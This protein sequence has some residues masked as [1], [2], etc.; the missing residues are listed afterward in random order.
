MFRPKK[1][2]LVVTGALMM[3]A[4]IALSGCGSDGGESPSAAIDPNASPESVTGALTVMRNPGEMTDEK[5]DDFKAQYPN[6]DLTV[7]DYDAVKLASLQAAG[8]AP[9]V[10]R[11][12]GPAVAP[13]VSQGLLLDLTAPFESAGVT[14]DTTYESANIYVFDGKRYGLPKDWS[15]DLTIF[16]NKS[17]F[18]QAGV[19]VPDPSEPI[20]W[21]EVRKLAADVKA[22]LPASSTIIPF[23]GAWDTFSPARFISAR[24]AESGQTLYSED[25]K[26]LN[27]VD[28]PD[29]VGFLQYMADMAKDG[30]TFSPLNPSA[31]YAGDDFTKGNVAMAM[32]GYWFNSQVN[33]GETAVGVNYSMIP[34]P[35]WSDQGSRVDPT[36]TGTGYVVSAGTKNPQ[37]AWEL[38][39]WYLTGDE[40]GKRA[41][42]AAGLPVLRSN[43]DL[44]PQDSD[45]NKQAFGVVTAEA[46][47]SPALQFNKYYDDSVFTTSYNKSLQEYLAGSISIEQVAQNIQDEVSA[48]IQDGVLAVGD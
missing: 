21:D 22:G 17:I 26:T 46:E 11:V 19:S 16:I 6:I 27:L 43:V 1:S 42:A 20:S 48:A 8:S 32:Y 34:A 40:A 38:M 7:I 35:Y 37:A 12:E 25:Q 33:S 29:A 10:F 45:V 44:L 24:L 47:D 14:D 23:G 2:R 39:K 36:V 13:L 9:D 41:E 5:L 3:A 31:S 30:L 18:Q 28:N 15:P 4:A